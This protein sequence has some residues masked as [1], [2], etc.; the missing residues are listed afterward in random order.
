L[1]LERGDGH[2]A[3][4][5][6][7]RGVFEA[8]TRNCPTGITRD[9]GPC[10]PAHARRY[11][12]RTQRNVTA[13]AMAL[14]LLVAPHAHAE[15]INE[16]HAIRHVL[17]ISIDGMHALDY[18]NCVQGGYCPISANLPLCP[19]LHAFFM[20]PFAV[21]QG[22]H[23]LDGPA[24]FAPWIPDAPDAVDDC[25]ESGANGGGTPGDGPPTTCPAPAAAAAPA[26][27]RAPPNCSLRRSRLTRGRSTQA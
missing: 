17:L 3:S 16:R 14:T 9:L 1:P 25:R 22:M 12:V 23:R 6:K 10:Y 20:P 2:G 26:P 27:T 15:H 24:S 19:V 7:H 21:C 11:T 13:F 4:P 18:T 8:H 5:P